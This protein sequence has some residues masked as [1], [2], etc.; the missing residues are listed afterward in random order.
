MRHVLGRGLTAVVAGMVIGLIV[1]AGVSRVLRIV[2]YGV[3]PG[4]PSTYAVVTLV[5]LGA[6]ILACAVPAQRLL[7]LNTVAALRHE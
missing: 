1:A 7:R 4:D 6:A 3:S 5:L 2:L